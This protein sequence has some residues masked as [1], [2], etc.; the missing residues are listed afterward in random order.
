MQA[1]LETNTTGLPGLYFSVEALDTPVKCE[2]STM[3][4]PWLKPRSPSLTAS[5][6]V[7]PP[8]IGIGVALVQGTAQNSCRKPGTPCGSVQSI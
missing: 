2:L 4:G 5:S 1:K 7:K 6:A 8:M 3:L